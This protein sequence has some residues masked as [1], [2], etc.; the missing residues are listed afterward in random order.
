MTK[1]NKIIHQIWSDKHNPL[2]AFFSVLSQTWK[3]KHPD[4]E[5]IN[6][7]DKS[8]N[9]FIEKEYGKYCDLYNSFPFDVQRWDAI[10]FLILKKYGGL[11]LDF[12][13]ECLENIEPLIEDSDCAIALEPEIHCLQYNVPHFL[14][15]AFFYSIP[16]HFFL[17]KII[18]KI[19]SIETLQYNRTNKPMCVLNTTGPLMVSNLYEKLQEVEKK[20]ISLIPAKY[21]TPFDS[22]QIQLVK[23]GVINDELEKCLDEAYAIHYFTNLW[24]GV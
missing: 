11:Y 13:Y 9:D 23:A 19:F 14:N 17:D 6:W 12:D 10:R 15:N 24:V 2:P 21:V 16:N 5:Y 8:M 3:E 22:M 1:K 7:D 4:W 20:Q 18:D